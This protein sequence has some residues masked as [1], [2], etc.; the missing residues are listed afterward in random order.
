MR[1]LA[2]LAL[3]AVSGCSDQ[4]TLWRESE[5]Q[6]IAGKASDEGNAALLVRINQLEYKLEKVEGDTT[7]AKITAE[8]TADAHQSLVKT[9][10]SNVDK[11]NAEAVKDMTRRGACGREWLQNE[12]GA[13]FQ[14]NKACTLADLKK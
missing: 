9:F 8:I 11:D 3:L 2:L 14:T 6:D 5:I 1:S 7:V 12:N 13:W 4:K 10:N